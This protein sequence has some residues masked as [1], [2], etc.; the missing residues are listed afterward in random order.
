ME[1]FLL[2]VVMRVAGPLL[3]MWV[4]TW[5]KVWKTSLRTR[6]KTLVKHYP[7]LHELLKSHEARGEWRLKHP[8]RDLNTALTVNNRWCYK[9]SPAFICEQSKGLQNRVTLHFKIS[10]AYY[11]LQHPCSIHTVAFL[12]YSMKYFYCYFYVSSNTLRK[13]G[14]IFDQNMFFKAQFEINM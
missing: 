12:C 3:I 8:S 14:V 9:S 7:P 11:I 1:A 4:I 5:T 10:S 2:E 13:L 6:C